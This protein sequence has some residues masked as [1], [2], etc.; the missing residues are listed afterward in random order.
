MIPVMMQESYKPQGWRKSQLEGFLHF[1][2]H[3]HAVDVCDTAKCSWL[4]A[5]NT[6]V[7]CLLGC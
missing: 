2:R 3:R 5:G 4:N 1:K 7:V 6:N